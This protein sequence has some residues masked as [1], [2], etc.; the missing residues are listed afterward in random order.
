MKTE[1]HE[2]LSKEELIKWAEEIRAAC[3][4]FGDVSA[5]KAAKEAIDTYL[6]DTF[7]FSVMGL[8]KRGKSTLVNALLGRNDDVFAPIGKRPATSVC[9]IFRPAEKQKVTVVFRSGEEREIAPEDLRFYATEDHNRGNVKEVALIRADYPFPENFQGITLVDLPGAESIHEHHDQVIH[10]FL[11]QSD[12]VLLMTTS[13][14]PISAGEID[15]LREVQKN[16]VGKIFVAMNKIDKCDEDEIAEGE[17]ANRRALAETDV[18]VGTIYKI[19]AKLAHDGETEKSGVPAMLGDIKD[20]VEKNRG[21]IMKKRL[22]ARILSAA[23]SVLHAADVNAAVSSLSP[24]E[25]QKLSKEL[26][27]KRDEL[28]AKNKTR[29]KEFKSRWD[30]AVDEFAARLPKIKTNVQIRLEKKMNQYGL[31]NVGKFKKEVPS[32]FAETLESELSDPSHDLENRLR[33]LTYQYDKDCPCICIAPDGTVVSESSSHAAEAAMVGAGTTLAV[34]G[35]L[36]ATVAGGLT[37]TVV[38]V[39]PW[40]TLGA[41]IA[42]S[43]GAA[44]STLAGAAGATTAIEIAGTGAVTTGL[45]DTVVASIGSLFS[46][47]GA[48]ASTAFTTAGTT[49]TTV[50]TTLAVVAGPIGWTIAGVGALAVPVAWGFK[51]NKDLNK[52]K[53]SVKSKIDEVFTSFCEKQIP[54]LKDAGARITEELDCLW[55]RQLAD[56]EASIK[57]AALD[58]KKAETKE[59]TLACRRRFKALLNFSG[60]KEARQ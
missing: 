34:G 49:A 13:R 58:E 37:T 28:T 35:G 50:P 18:P 1:K 33:D 45:L 23:Q 39:A 26:E 48:T 9:T 11:P 54:A 22:V 41:G 15:L 6:T 51:R 44:G 8:A 57:R 5:E 43:I 10:Q 7:V 42:S 55:E 12:A 36:F 25:L 53:N 52:L 40:A 19:S 17:A 14:I 60:N 24:D 20:F 46:G 30:G 38:S 16:D 29:R 59:Q 56:M 47:L 4:E 32:F 31:M 3:A 21:A 27:I 2:N